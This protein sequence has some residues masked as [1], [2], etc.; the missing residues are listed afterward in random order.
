LRA[1][2]E[3]RYIER[4]ENTPRVAVAL[5]LIQQ[6]FTRRSIVEDALLSEEEFAAVGETFDRLV[7]WI[8]PAP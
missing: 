5:S 1:L 3:R 8:P 7:F 2:A 4:M 6:M